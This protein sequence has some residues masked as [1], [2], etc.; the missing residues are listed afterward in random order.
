MEIRSSYLGGVNPD[1]QNILNDQDQLEKIAQQIANDTG[2]Q[3]AINLD[4]AKY[5]STYAQFSSDQSKAIADGAL[6]PLTDPFWTQTNNDMSAFSNLVANV[7]D[8]ARAGNKD[9][10]NT[11]YSTASQQSEQVMI[12]YLNYHSPV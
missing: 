9:K 10:A 4:I 12:D 6:P 3:T 11:D 2:N 8:D 5:N 1:I 7:I